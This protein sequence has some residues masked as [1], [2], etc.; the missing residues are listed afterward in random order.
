MSQELLGAA[1]GRTKMTISQFEQG[2]TA[3]PRGELLEKII[4][5]LGASEKEA[6]TL[7]FLAAS[8]RRAI[9]EDIY[10]YF[11]SSPLIYST[12][13]MAKETGADEATWAKFLSSMEDKNA[14]GE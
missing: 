7:R 12:I 2:K 1:V 14:A 5:A 11:F 13:K 4:D 3:P 10:E 6:K 8:Q 9:P